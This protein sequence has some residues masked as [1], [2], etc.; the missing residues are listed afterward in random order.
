LALID[1]DFKNNG[2]SPRR[3]LTQETLVSKLQPK[4]DR[5]VRRLRHSDGRTA[6]EFLAICGIFHEE[7]AQARRSRRL[8][9]ED[10]AA[11]LRHPRALLLP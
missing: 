4:I 5:W 8:V 3:E 11:V 6:G 10:Q 9:F 1:T 7:V 2:P